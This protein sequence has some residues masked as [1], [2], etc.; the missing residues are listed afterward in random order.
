MD[1]EIIVFCAMVMIGCT[2]A[3]CLTI[4]NCQPKVYVESKPNVYVTLMQPQPET[5]PATLPA[6]EK[7]SK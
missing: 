5:A 2:V 6:I 3:I 7:E 4:G 1:D